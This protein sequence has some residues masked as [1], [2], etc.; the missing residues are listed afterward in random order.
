MTVT[1]RKQPT[2]ESLAD[3]NAAPLSSSGVKASCDSCSAD[4]TH[5][6]HVRCA[7]TVKG[8]A[9]LNNSNDLN[10]ASTSTAGDRLICPDFDL[11]VPVSFFNYY[12]Y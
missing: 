4:I 10:G 2:R 5:S 7:E 3:P 9:G 8:G 1:K 6:V 12:Y 11:C